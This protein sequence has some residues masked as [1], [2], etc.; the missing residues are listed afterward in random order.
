MYPKVEVSNSLIIPRLIIT[1]LAVS[2]PLLLLLLLF[3][4][5]NCMGS[6]LVSCPAHQVPFSCFAPDIIE[7]YTH[8][9]TKKSYKSARGAIINV[10]FF[11]LSSSAS[12]VTNTQVIGYDYLNQQTQKNSFVHQSISF[13]SFFLPRWTKSLIAGLSCRGVTTSTAVG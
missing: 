5:P 7:V 9:H 3:S 11:L 6:G 1:L 8:T 10:S 13:L 12:C 4:R 2:V